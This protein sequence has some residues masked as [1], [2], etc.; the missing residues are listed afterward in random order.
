MKKD[1]SN[2]KGTMAADMAATTNRISKLIYES[3]LSDREIGEL[4]GL[5]SQTINK[6]R[7]GNGLPDMENLFMLSRILGIRMDDFFVVQSIYY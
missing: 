3:G 4:M 1:F 6:W 7:H 5:T 2:R